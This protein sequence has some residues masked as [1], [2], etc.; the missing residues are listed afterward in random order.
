M[1][2]IERFHVGLDPIFGSLLSEWFPGEVVILKQFLHEHR[3][4]LRT[5]GWF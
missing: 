2:V 4:R 3:S 5:S 1:I